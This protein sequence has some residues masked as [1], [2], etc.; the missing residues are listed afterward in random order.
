MKVYGYGYALS[1]GKCELIIG[2]AVTKMIPFLN[3]FIGGG[4][5]FNQIDDWLFLQI[6]FFWGLSA[7]FYWYVKRLDRI[8][9][10]EVFETIGSSDKRRL[11]IEVT[12]LGH[13]KINNITPYNMNWLERSMWM[14]LLVTVAFLVYFFSSGLKVSPE[15]WLLYGMCLAVVTGIPFLL[16][17]TRNDYWAFMLRRGRICLD[18]GV[19]G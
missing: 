11:G 13:W 10:D 12:P 5:L 9:M 15:S 3:V 17:A 8:V 16:V 2:E 19:S 18:P 1:T 4:M 14:Y 7:F 6:L